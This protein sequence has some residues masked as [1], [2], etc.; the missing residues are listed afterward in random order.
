MAVIYLRNTRALT[1]GDPGVQIV[2]LLTVRE[3][4]RQTF[5]AH[6]G[7]GGPLVYDHVGDELT[8]AFTFANQEAASDFMANAESNAIIRVDEFGSAQRD[9][10]IKNV[11]ATGVGGNVSDAQ[12]LRPG[13]VSVDAR[14]RFETGDTRATMITSAPVA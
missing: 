1:H 3:T 12:A 5:V 10:T 4:H 2:G 13:E 6:G 11:Q 9:Y 14:A 8:F 7:D